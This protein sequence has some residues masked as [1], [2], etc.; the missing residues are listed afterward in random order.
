MLA[1]QD[2]EAVDKILKHIPTHI[3]PSLEM[4]KFLTRLREEIKTDY[5]VGLMKAIGKAHSV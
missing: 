1:P 3:L 2:M 5:R 4:E